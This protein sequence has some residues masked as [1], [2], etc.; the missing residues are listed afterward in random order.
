MSTSLSPSVHILLLAAKKLI[1]LYLGEMGKFTGAM[2]ISS[3]LAFL[4]RYGGGGKHDRAVFSPLD[5]Q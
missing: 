5:D 4:Y 1:T 3:C 2:L